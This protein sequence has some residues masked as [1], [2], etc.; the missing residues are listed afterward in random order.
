MAVEDYHIRR[1][2]TFKRDIYFKDS[3]GAVIPLVGYTVVMSIDQGDFHYAVGL[4]VDEP[5]GKITF[6]IPPEDTE[7]FP[8]EAY[9]LMTTVKTASQ[10][11]D[12]LL[13]GTVS[14]LPL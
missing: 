1:G 13:E 6:N 9:H 2:T 12:I 5:G 14:T 11:V 8:A 3:T 4:T 10:E 7:T